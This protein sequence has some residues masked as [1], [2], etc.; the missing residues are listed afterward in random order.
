MGCND[1]MQVD[2]ISCETRGVDFIFFQPVAFIF[3]FPSSL[4]LLSVRYSRLSVRLSV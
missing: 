3:F 4:S 2:G 1:E